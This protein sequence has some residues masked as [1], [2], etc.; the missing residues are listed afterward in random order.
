[1]TSIS[2]PRNTCKKVLYKYNK[3]MS[4]ERIA[5]IGIPGS[6]KSTFAR[7]LEKK[8][9]RPVV[10]LDKHFWT[11]DWKE[12]FPTR[13]EW[14]QYANKFTESET[15]IIDG[16][17]MKTMD[18]RIERATTII[19]FDFPKWLCI[20]RSFKRIFNRAQPFDKPEGAKERIGWKLVKFIID[21]PNKEIEQKIN[22]YKDLKDVF[23]VRN[24]LEVK[25]LLNNIN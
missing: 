22:Q 8:I 7:K 9:G 1:M 17:Y 25:N 24:N 23:I 16:N 10:Y 12:R 21:Y 19:F 5:I 15:W 4:Y 14:R 20:W 11:P 18:V 2:R 3:T 6:G 13:E